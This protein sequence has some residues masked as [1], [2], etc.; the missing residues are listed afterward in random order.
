[1]ELGLV[2]DFVVVDST[3]GHLSFTKTKVSNFSPRLKTGVRP[4]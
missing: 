1:M 4:N 3:L 2:L